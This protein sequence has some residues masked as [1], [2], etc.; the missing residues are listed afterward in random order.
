MPRKKMTKNIF[1]SPYHDRHALVTP[2]ELNG[3]I[4]SDERV[5][6]V[7]SGAEALLVANVD[8]EGQQVFRQ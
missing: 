8:K 3:Y 7:Q 1:K 5:A 6:R 4:W 2:G